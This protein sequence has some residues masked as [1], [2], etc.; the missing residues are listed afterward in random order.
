MTSDRVRGQ[1]P[2]RAGRTEWVPEKRAQNERRGW[3]EVA[4]LRKKE[5]R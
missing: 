2:G 4:G 1:G 5:G 3:G